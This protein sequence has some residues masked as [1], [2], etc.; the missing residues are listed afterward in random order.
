MGFQADRLRKGQPEGRASSDCQEDFNGSIYW[1]SD[2]NGTST[3]PWK[4]TGD[5]VRQQGM[6]FG[7]LQWEGRSSA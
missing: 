2:E 6:E 4:D 7:A 1:P 5:E 3:I